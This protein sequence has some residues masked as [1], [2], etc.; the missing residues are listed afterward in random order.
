MASRKLG[1]GRILGSGRGLVAPTL[2]DSTENG[3]PD[4]QDGTSSFGTSPSISLPV[5]N[6]VEN[7]QDLT[8]RV[9]LARE[10]SPAPAIASKL[11]CPICAEEMV[12]LVHNICSE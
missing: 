4:S 6:L 5:E 9:S 2:K 8:S 3:T 10:S 7:A 11:V 12:S 1:G